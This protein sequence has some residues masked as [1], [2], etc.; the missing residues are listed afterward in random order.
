MAIFHFFIFY[1]SVVSESKSIFIEEGYPLLVAFSVLFVLM[2]LS[3]LFFPHILY[4]MPVKIFLP[5]EQLQPQNLPEPLLV[6]NKM[7]ELEVN[8]TEILSTNQPAEKFIQLFS[9]EYIKEIDIKLKVWIGSKTF[10]DPETN[11]S[12]LAVQIKIPQ[13]HLSY[14][15][16]TILD[17]KFTDWRN[18]LKIDYAVSLIDQGFKKSLTLEALSIQ[19]GF[20]SQS[21]FIRAFKNAKGMTPSEYMKGG[22]A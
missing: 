21:T 19:S 13:H 20:L 14:Y 6:E 7:E 18:N 11:I 2:I 17:I 5:S 16:N 1:T 12:S 3:L 8:S 15:F 9:E 22:E 4:G 10:L